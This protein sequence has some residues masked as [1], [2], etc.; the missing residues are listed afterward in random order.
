MPR[1]SFDKAFKIAAV[2]LVTEEGFSVYGKMFVGHLWL[3]SFVFFRRKYNLS[4]P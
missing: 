3:H 1:R 4:V 2:K